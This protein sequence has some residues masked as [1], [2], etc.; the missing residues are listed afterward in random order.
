MSDSSRAQ[1]RRLKEAAWGVTPASAMKNVRFTGENLKYAIG[2]VRSNEIRSDRMVTDIIQTTFEANGGFSFELSAANIDDELEGVLF[3]AGWSTAINISATDISAAAADDSFNSVT[4]DFT[5]KNISV[6]Q[7]IKVSGF[8]TA[9]NNGYFKVVSVAANKIVTNG[10]LTDEV[11]GDTVVM[12]GSMIRNGTTMSSWT[13]EKEFNDIVQ[14]MVYK[15]MVPNVLN[16]SLE[17]QSII[18]GS[19]EYVGKDGVLQQVSAGTGAAT[20]APANQVMNTGVHVG[21]IREGGAEVT[22]AHIKTL[23]MAI[24]NNLRGKPAVK[25]VGNAGIGAGSINVTG[26]MV[27]YFEDETLFSKYMDGVATSV[28]FRVTDDSGKSN[29]VTMNNVKFTDGDV[30]ATGANQDVMASLQFEAIRDVTTNSVIQVD[31]FGYTV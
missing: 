30:L 19:I 21:S 3:S 15:G 26:T 11:A 16:L 4:T 1:I 18:T 24:N 8:T 13:V 7:W 17:A 25:V 14:F 27:A 6:G 2:G 22:S 28:D 12:S 20:D 29:I 31:R 23:T 10:T 9:A 5:T